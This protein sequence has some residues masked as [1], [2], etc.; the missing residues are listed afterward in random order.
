VHALVCCVLA[1]LLKACV[2]WVVVLGHFSAIL[3]TVHG[4]SVRKHRVLKTKKN[5]M[6][7]IF[8]WTASYFYKSLYPPN[9]LSYLSYPMVSNAFA[10]FCD[11]IYI[12]RHTYIHTCKLHV[13]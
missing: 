7:W 5:E 2:A 6:K 10:R 3:I 8:F 12:F 1:P 13:H 9:Y 11:W 4:S